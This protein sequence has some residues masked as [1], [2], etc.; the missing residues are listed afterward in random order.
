MT[1]GNFLKQLL[2]DRAAAARLA[3]VLMAMVM[4]ILAGKIWE[5][6]YLESLRDDCGF[7]FR[8]RLIPAATL[9]HLSD[10]VHT[11]RETLEEFLSGQSDET[12]PRVD[13]RLGQHDAAIMGAIEQIEKTYL[14]DE[15][16][17]LLGEF[18]RE[19]RRLYAARNRVA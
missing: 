15:E 17:R 10:Q 8:D 18:P 4:T 12:P 16:S 3:I 7:L 11:K 6:T 13:Y 14:V 19:V 9:F 2:G 1:K 5:D